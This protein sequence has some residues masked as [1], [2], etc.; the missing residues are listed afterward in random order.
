MPTGGIWLR[1]TRLKE[2]FITT[3]LPLARVPASTFLLHN[4]IFDI[5]HSATVT[6]YRD[7][8]L[9]YCQVNSWCNMSFFPY[10]SWLTKTNR[11]HQKKRYPSWEFCQVFCGSDFS[12]WIVHG[13]PLFICS[14]HF[15]FI[16]FPSDFF[17]QL[18][19][20][21]LPPP[22]SPNCQFLWGGT[23]PSTEVKSL[24]D[25]HPDWEN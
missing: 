20:H 17:T 24:T 9:H 10:S 1:K 19:C 22:P 21:V 13:T 8:F 6:V 7:Y 12:G 11:T 14:P 3:R 23:F 15:H 2:E 5:T 18:I 25:L 4:Y 16:K